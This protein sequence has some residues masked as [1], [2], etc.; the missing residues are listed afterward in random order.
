MGHFMKGFLE[1]DG[2]VCDVEY[3]VKHRKDPGVLVD[4][5]KKSEFVII[6]FPLY[7]DGMPGSVKQFFEHLAPLVGR[8]GNPALG[9]VIQCGFPE[10]HHT[11]FVEKYVAKL[12]KRLNCRYLGAILKGG[13]EGL[14][15][16]PPFLTEK[17]YEYFYQLGRA[18]GLEGAFD[19]TLCAKLARPEHLSRENLEQVIPFVNSALWDMLLEQN[20]A[21]DKSFDRPYQS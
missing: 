6:G 10:T 19:A 14:A 3:L 16:Q 13:C 12:A 4:I 9:F 7:V 21:K 2:N 5:Y 8:E 18:F 20:G 11:R 1:K 15:I 17:Y